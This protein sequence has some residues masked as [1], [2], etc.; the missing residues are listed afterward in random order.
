M[1]ILY[2]R[3]HTLK[4]I[5]RQEQRSV[6]VCLRLSNSTAFLIVCLRKL[7]GGWSIFFVYLPN[8]PLNCGTFL[9]SSALLWRLEHRM[10]SSQQRNMPAGIKNIVD[11]MTSSKRWEKNSTGSIVQFIYITLCF[12]S[13]LCSCT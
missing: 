5:T 3:K 12:D 13:H 8:L 10:L 1:T 2:V 4:I 6:G 9:T 11:L 7:F